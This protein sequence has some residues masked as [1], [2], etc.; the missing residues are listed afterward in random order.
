[1]DSPIPDRIEAILAR[2]NEPVMP[3]D[4]IGRWLDRFPGEDRQAAVLLL[5]KIEYHS[6]PRLLRECRELHSLVC[7]RLAADGFDLVEF[8]DVDFSREFTCK[9][10]DIISYLYRKANAV[11][12][13]DFKTFDRLISESATCPNGSCDRALVILDDFIGT[14][15]QFIFQFLA[16]S[17]EDV[18]VLESYR[19]VYLASVVIHDNALEKLAL[20]QAGECRKVLSIEEAQFPDYDWAWEEGELENALF[21]IDWNRIGF[22]WVEREHPLLSEKNGSIP[23]EERAVLS[24]FLRKY[25]GD[26]KLSTSYLDGH[27][28]FFYGAPN[29]LPKVLLPLFSRVEDLSIYPTEHFIG[30]DTGIVN[31]KMD[32]GKE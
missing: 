14:G 5:E 21:R 7:G 17:R 22:V 3:E 31:W 9:S 2:F 12:S 4:R 19:K 20:L 1:M 32:D 25:G 30:V 13:V 28:T 29:S 23:D 27:H 10:G 26:T 11:P 15:S 8:T 24:Q 16:R 18:R 6:Y